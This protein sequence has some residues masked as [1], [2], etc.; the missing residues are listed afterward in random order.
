MIYCNVNGNRSRAI[1]DYKDCLEE[2]NKSSFKSTEIPSME[3]GD[4]KDRIYSSNKILVSLLE[5]GYHK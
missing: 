3:V 5:D 2:T 1:I 4:Q